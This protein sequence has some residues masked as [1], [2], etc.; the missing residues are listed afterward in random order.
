MMTRRLSTT[1]RRAITGIALC[2][3]LAVLL[4]LDLRAHG[5]AWQTMFNLTGEESPLG[6]IRGMIELGSNLTRPPLNLA[7]DTTLRNTLVGPYITPY[8]IN[9]FLEQEAEVAKRERSL[10][11]IHD[12]GFGW[13][14]Q[15]FSW[16]DIE[17]HGRGDFE[18]RRNLEVTGGP[19]S[20]W[21]KYD[22]IVDLAQQYNVQIMARLDNPPAW[23]H[24]NP[25]IGDFAPPDDVQD[26]VNY[27]TA[28]AERYYGRIHVYQV[29]NEP[30][31]YPEWGNQTV[32]PAAYTDMLCR[33]YRAL[34]EVDPSIIVVTGALAPTLELSGRDLNDLIFLQRMY[35]AGAGECFD[36]LSAQAYGFFSAATD[37][38][39]R[40]TTI[41]FTHHRYVRDVMVANGDADKAIWLSE[42]AWNPIDSPEVPPDVQNREGYGVV[43]QEEAARYMPQAY[44]LTEEN[45]PYIGVMFYWFFKRPAEYERNQ[46][47]YYF[48]MVEPDF[49]PLPVYDAM[50]DYIHTHTPMLYR[51]MHPPDDLG[52]MNSIGVER[53]NDPHMPYGYAMAITGGLYSSYPVSGTDVRFR[54]SSSEDTGSALVSVN[55][56]RTAVVFPHDQPYVTIP[57][58]FVRTSATVTINSYDSPIMVESVQVIDHTVDN[59][60]RAALIIGVPVMFVGIGLVIA[61]WSRLAKRRKPT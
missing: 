44:Q 49:T 56:V 20:A 5:L 25:D 48:R 38:R 40:P 12:A 8:G 59:L 37:Q 51:G 11:M 18:D 24:A 55:G 32:D 16:A 2:L 35:D 26:F 60:F 57:L 1:L 27:A 54:L 43:T 41:T 4:G 31:I 6:Q 10:Q 9:T 30:N 22:N 61:V 29:W 45:Y 19:I 7:I 47:W 17:I 28:V 23:T 15:Q 42:A 13:I 52:I 50:R 14:R 39:T 21:D 3:I 34:K 33:T 53:V 46:S 58:G 36:V